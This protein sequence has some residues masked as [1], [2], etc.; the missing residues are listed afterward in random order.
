MRTRTKVV[1]SMIVVAALLSSLLL[2]T[3]QYKPTMGA[4][5]DPWGKGEVLNY[6]FFP[7]AELGLDQREVDN[8]LAWKR[9]TNCLLYTSPSPRD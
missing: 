1:C 2:L 8:Y 3:G 9:D 5:A 7:D 4:T 6:I